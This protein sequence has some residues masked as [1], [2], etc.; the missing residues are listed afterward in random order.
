MSC[1]IQVN[2]HTGSLEDEKQDAVAFEDLVRSLR[3]VPSMSGLSGTLAAS[4]TA[5][6]RNA[7]DV[8]DAPE[9]E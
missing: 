3:K 2:G 1:G 9:G 5:N 4:D 6:A 7:D 8:V